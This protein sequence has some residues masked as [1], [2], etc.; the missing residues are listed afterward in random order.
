MTKPTLGKKS[1]K[2]PLQRIPL[3]KTTKGEMLLA[4]FSQQM[5][6]KIPFSLKI[7]VSSVRL[8]LMALI[9]TER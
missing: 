2:L 6:L 1:Q 9:L 5:E 4:D 7:V 8:N 3:H